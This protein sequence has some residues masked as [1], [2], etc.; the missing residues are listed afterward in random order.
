MLKQLDL[1]QGPLGQDL[2]AENIGD[3]FN[4]NTFAG[5]AVCGGAVIWSDEG[6][7]VDMVCAGGTGPLSALKH[8]PDDAV[9]SLTQF[10]GH[11]VPFIDGE[12]LV[13]DFE[14]SAALHVCHDCW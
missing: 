7:D 2:F 8:V 4:G 9:C 3:L 14:D 5:H 6:R 1:S 13:E 11:I 10:L 12:V